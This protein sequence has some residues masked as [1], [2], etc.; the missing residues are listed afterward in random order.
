[1]SFSAE[2]QQEI[3]RLQQLQQNLEQIR[4]HRIQLERRQSELKIT[5]EAVSNLDDEQEVYKTVGQLMLTTKIGAAKAEMSAELD[6][7][8]AKLIG[9]K[10]REKSLE[11]RFNEGQQKLRAQIGQ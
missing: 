9:V 7:L 5:L 3:Q 2:Q 1:M 4:N 10:S 8:E 11:E 6:D